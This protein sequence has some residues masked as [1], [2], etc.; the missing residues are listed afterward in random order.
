[1]DLPLPV[2]PTSATVCPPSTVSEKSSEHVPRRRCSGRKRDRIRYRRGSPASFRV[3]GWKL[4]PNFSTTS[5]RVVRS[6]A[7][8]PACSARVPPPP[9]T[10]AKSAKMRA[11]R[12]DRL[13]DAG[14][15][16]DERGKRADREHLRMQIIDLVT[17]LGRAPSP[18][19]ARR[20]T[21]TIGMNSALMHRG[22]N[23]R[24]SSSCRS[25]PRIPRYS[26]F[27]G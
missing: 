14:G 13:E 22:V 20:A 7:R 25:E 21:A 10:P 16:L 26:P 5:G 27:R 11:M 6:P 1:M 3:F 23:R 19:P 24:P 2:S 12:A 9:A 4:S 18:S 15:V 8:S 17:A